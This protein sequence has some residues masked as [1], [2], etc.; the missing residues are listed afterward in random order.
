ML[1]R[2]F[3]LLL[4]L[5]LLP[6]PAVSAELVI[7][8]SILPQKTFVEAI[9]GSHATVQALVK[10]GLSP[11]TYEPTPRQMAALSKADAYYRMGVAFETPWLPKICAR[12]PDLKVFDARTN[13]PLRNMASGQHYEQHAG[14]H[15]GERGPH[16]STGKDP[17]IWLDP[18]RVMIMAD[19][20]LAMIQ[21]LDPQHTEEYA[22]NH[23]RFVSRL[24]QLDQWLE[25]TLAP[26]KYRKFMVFHPSWGYFAERYGLQQLAVEQEGKSPGA[27]SLARLIQQAKNEG[28]HVVFVQKQFSS[29]Y[30]KTIAEA[31]GGKV[32]PIDPL[33]PNYFENLKHVA[34]AIVEAQP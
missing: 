1:L 27:R 23:H 14:E 11:A 10:P 15:S 6:L 33:A 26:V 4:L 5:F 8:T 25:N 24:K 13:V 34:N 32:D 16:E 7:F 3:K 21:E 18:Q 12:H 19:G 29:Q 28:I 17:H 20:I 30:A 2:L 31:I 22:A 9:T